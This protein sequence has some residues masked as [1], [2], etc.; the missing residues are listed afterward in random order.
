M[1]FIHWTTQMSNKSILLTDFKSTLTIKDEIKLKD[2]VTNTVPV[3]NN[4]S[5][6]L[7]AED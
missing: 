5:L 6:S 3:V 2:D 7:T 1:R 4:T